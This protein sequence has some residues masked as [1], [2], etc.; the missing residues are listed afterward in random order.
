MAASV[1]RW[2][3]F[4]IS[5]L[6]KAEGNPFTDYT[7]RGVFRHKNEIVETDGFYDGDGVYKVR[8]MPSFEGEY[9]FDVSGTFSDEKTLTGTFT[10][11]P[12]G[13][14]N[15]GPV[16]VASKYH[17]AYKDSTPYYPIGTTCYAWTH[18]SEEMRDKTLE[19]LKNNVFNKIRFCILP[20][21]HLYNFN[22]PETYPYE[23]T[24]CDSSVLTEENFN[25]SSVWKGN[26]WDFTKFNPEH[27]RRFESYVAELMKMG[28][29][30]DVIVMHPY[31]RWGFRNMSKKDDDLYWNYVVSRLSAYRNVWWSLANEYD[32]MTEKT[33]DDWERYASILC[34]KD[35][36]NHL[37]SI[38]NC[39]AMYD[40]SR[41]WITHI[42]YQVSPCGDV[43]YTNELREKYGKPVVL[44]EMR[45]EGNIPYGWGNLDGRELVR[46]FWEVMCRGGYPGHSETL[47]QSNG[48]LWWSHGGELLGESPQRIKFLY[49]IM[50]ET[51]GHGLKL[52]YSEDGYVMAEPEDA[53][54]NPGYFIVYFGVSQSGFYDFQSDKETSY[55]AEIIDAWNMTITD[56][57]VYK[58]GS[59]INLPRKP[60]LALRLKEYVTV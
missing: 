37:C 34:R 36:Y 6:G 39:N 10:V 23:G 59:R 25:D 43:E 41:P 30:A 57:G 16:R 35:P 22:E 3:M 40:H 47:V 53:Y 24:P 58:S 1:E 8:F 51:P 20:K 19:T 38:H 9:T 13:E 5:T 52:A 54:A 33:T 4:E 15:H 11:T 56:A 60:Y 7:I 31:D 45:Y 48:K 50:T 14:R 18:Q 12:A 21:H 42:S 46:R 29:E 17:F 32:V 26:D 55:R 2:G 49:E 28:I 27:F 44:D